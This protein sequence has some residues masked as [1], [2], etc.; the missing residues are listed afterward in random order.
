MKPMRASWFNL[1]LA[2]VVLGAAA[3]ARG[4][5]SKSDARPSKYEDPT[6]LTAAI[7]APGTKNLLFKFKRSATRSGAILSV[8][9]DF[10]YPEGNPAASEHVIYQGDQLMKYELN[11]AQIGAGG[12]ARI[13][14]SP[15]DPAKG[16]IEF[17][18]HAGPDSRLK[19]ST[20]TLE[21]DTL[22]ADMIAPFLTSHWRALMG[23][24]KLRCRYIVV[25]R[26]ETVGFTFVKDTKGAENRPDVTVIKM[27]P[28][29][30]IIAALVKPIFFTFETA[31]PHNVID[32]T[33]R[34]TPKLQVKGKFKD[35]DA[36]TVFDPPTAR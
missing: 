28:T 16:K 32:C 1:L 20:E 3:S 2:V 21:P 14:R 27:E 11:E 23:G 25:Q 36:F 4:Q 5:D 18:Y 6:N 10:T 26:L 13:R 17:D 19:T 15:T 24:E 35:L 8:Q 22:V 7:Y 34:T 30:T 33:G 9:R 31:P 29:S 12:S